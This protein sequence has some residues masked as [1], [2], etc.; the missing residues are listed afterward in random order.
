MMLAAL[1]VGVAEAAP[2]AASGKV[3]AGTASR[4]ERRDNWLMV[5]TSGSGNGVP[6]LNVRR[7]ARAAFRAD[8]RKATVRRQRFRRTTPPGTNRLVRGEIGTRKRRRPVIALGQS[9]REYS[10][11]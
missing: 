11:S 2:V 9:N 8:V 7:L 4:T 1:S 6:G 5:I 10:P 3:V